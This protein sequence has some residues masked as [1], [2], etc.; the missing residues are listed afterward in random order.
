[1]GKCEL[2]LIYQPLIGKEKLN[3]REGIKL[4][5]STDDFVIQFV[6]KLIDV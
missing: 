6:F 4:Y 1:M 5:K 2:K 3:R